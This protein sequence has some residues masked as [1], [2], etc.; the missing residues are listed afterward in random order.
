MA[1]LVQSQSWE[2][3]RNMDICMETGRWSSR[4]TARLCVKEAIRVLPSETLPPA[5]R[6]AV[7]AWS[8]RL[9]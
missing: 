9:G 6:V 1:D 8:R 3:T 5:T 4:R 7:E 2:S